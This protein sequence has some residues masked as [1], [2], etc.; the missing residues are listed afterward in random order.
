MWALLK[1]SVIAAG[2][3]R[4]AR[5]LHRQLRPAQQRA[6]DDDVALYRSLVTPGAL[7]FD[8]GANIGEKSEAL[9]AAGARVVAFEPNP[10][11]LPELLARC[12]FHPDWTLVPTALGSRDAIS[13][14]YLRASHGQSGLVREWEGSVYATVQIPVVTLDAAVRA[15]G[16]PA[17][18]KIDVEGWELEVLKG[19]SEPIPLLSFEFH[20]SA[21][22]LP[23]AHACLEHLAAFG[24]SHVNLTG[25]E[26]AAWHFRDWMPLAEFRRW[27]P[28]DIVEPYGDIVVRNDA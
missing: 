20:L 3:Y 10:S 14:L 27:F 7:C 9:L 16:R 13:P 26:T 11:I 1:Q 8:V 19:L 5:W 28:G 18:C 23:K 6:F 22:E 21:A 12:A 4:P 25:V 24:P 15:F 2:L 17:F